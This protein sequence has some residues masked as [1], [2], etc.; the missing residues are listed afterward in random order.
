MEHDFALV[1]LACDGNQ[2]FAVISVCLNVQ[3][4]GNIFGGNLFRL[5]ETF[6]GIRLR[7][8]LNRVF[9]ITGLNRHDILIAVF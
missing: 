9:L 3:I 1:L 4:L 6:Y 2:T 8:V 5:F 7:F